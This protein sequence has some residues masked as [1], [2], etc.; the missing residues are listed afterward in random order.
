MQLFQGDLLDAAFVRGLVR[1]VC[2]TH[3]FHL[4]AQPS[5]PVSWAKPIETFQN[6][7][8]GQLNLLEAVVESKPKTRVL[9]VG[10]RDEYGLAQPT[11]M[12]INENNPF[13]PN[14][15]YS[16]SKIAQDMLG[17]QYFLSHGL[18]VIRVRPFNHIGP[19]QNEEFV[20]SSFAKQIAEAELG[21]R[22]PTI[23]VGN[24]DAKRDFTDVRDM[25]RAYWLALTKGRPGEVY[26]LG[27]G[28][29]VRIGEILRI[30][31]RKSGITVGIV[32][33]ESRLRR[34]DVSE[35]V[36]DASKFRGEMGWRP[37]IPLDK[38]LQDILDYWRSQLR[39]VCHLS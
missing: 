36:C 15:P 14:N 25:V 39:Q 9:V 35:L 10:S 24:L 11:E 34:A 2:P 17:Y 22:E 30:L 5:I 18:S 6:N 20:A 37:E 29:A 13:R 1:K 23:Y 31:L 32:K 33:E 8:L 27:S 7:V 26:N 4:A 38:T 16:V 12:P 19:R 3:I 28:Q 21:L